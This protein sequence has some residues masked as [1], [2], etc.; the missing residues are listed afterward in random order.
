MQSVSQSVCL[1]GLVGSLKRI[2]WCNPSLCVATADWP[3]D[4]PRAGEWPG[5]DRLHRGEA[6]REGGRHH[7]EGCVRSDQSHCR[8][9]HSLCLRH[10]LSWKIKTIVEIV[11]RSYRCNKH[12]LKYV[13]GLV[14]NAFEV[15]NQNTHQMNG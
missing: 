7:R 6:G 4:C 13:P 12:A 5:C 14:D 3:E 9:N 8:Y 10:S 1:A 2:L 11:T 15:P